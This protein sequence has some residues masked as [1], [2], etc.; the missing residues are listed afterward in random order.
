MVDSELMDPPDLKLNNELDIAD[1]MAKKE[2]R[3][4][5]AEVSKWGI[6]VEQVTGQ[7]A[8]NFDNPTLLRGRLVRYLIRSREIAVGRGAQEQ[9]VDEDLPL[10]GPASK[11]SRRQAFIKL[12]NSGEFYLAIE[13]PF[14]FDCLS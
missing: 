12:I 14:V 8:P 1:R 11:V 7:P 5:E 6:V 13:V 3:R 10:E 2:I 9:T 4:L